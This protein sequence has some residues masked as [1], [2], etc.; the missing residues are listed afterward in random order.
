[1]T[2]ND[3]LTL[4]AIA[5]LAD[6]RIRDLELVEFCHEAQSLNQ[7]Y[8]PERILSRTA[9]RK[10]FDD[11]QL[12]IKNTLAGPSRKDFISTAL[13]RIDDVPMR[14]HILQSIFGII[15]CDYELHDEESNFI[16]AAVQAWDME[17]KALIGSPANTARPK[18][19]VPKG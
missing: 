13:A 7:H 14:P 18:N 10:W 19:P 11:N 9:L 16:K 2:W 4:L 8:D 5:V 17:S 1:M 3:I 15:V 12:V 6:N